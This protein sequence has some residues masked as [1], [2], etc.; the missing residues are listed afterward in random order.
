MTAAFMRAPPTYCEHLNA[1]RAGRLSPPAVSFTCTYTYPLFEKHSKRRKV[2][3]E[4]TTAW[5]ESRQK[6]M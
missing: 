4:I 5:D 3:K 1:N 2:T 6:K